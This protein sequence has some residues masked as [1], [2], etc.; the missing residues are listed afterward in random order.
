M[1]EAVRRRV[2]YRAG[3]VEVENMKIPKETESSMLQ[4]AVEILGRGYVP[5]LLV[6]VFV[7]ELRW[8]Y[9]LGYNAAKAEA[10]KKVKKPL[11]KKQLER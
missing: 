1:G 10:K 11:D 8:A 7:S 2:P 5:G 4:V 9:E 3:T 6:I